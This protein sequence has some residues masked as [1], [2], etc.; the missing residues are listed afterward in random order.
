MTKRSQ[1]AVGDC[2][3]TS[4]VT[5]RVGPV[6]R[7]GRRPKLAIVLS[8]G[9]ARGAYEAGVI[10]YIREDLAA[11]LGGQP[12]FD[13]ICGTSVGALHAC[14]MAATAD[15]PALQ[16][17]LLVERWQDLVLE[18][19]VSFGFKDLRRLPRILFGKAEVE[20]WERGEL[21]L[22]G[23]VET[24][25]LERLVGR[26]M[27][28]RGIR[29]NRNRGLFESLSV[30]TTDVASGKTVVFIDSAKEIPAW[31]RDPHRSARPA[32]IGPRHCLASAAIPLLFPAVAIDK[33]FYADGGLRQ[34]T[35][36]SPA[37]R[38]GADKVLVISLRSD[39]ERTLP[40]NDLDPTPFPS[41]VFLTSKLLDAFLLD[42]LDYDLERLRRLNSLM[43][44]IEK[45]GD[46]PL[47]QAVADVMKK[48][49]GGAYRPVQELVVAPSVNLGRLAAEAAQAGRFKGKGGG[50]GIRLLRR[51]A[52]SGDVSEQSDLLSYILFDGAF[53]ADLAQVGY[54]DARARHDEL[55]A[56]LSDC[57]A[58][59]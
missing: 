48:T 12:C 24:R 35:P 47:R 41:A 46:E 29:R 5:H 31:S 36:L 38:L 26:M 57:V 58:G 56:F 17:R 43:D 40:V 45:Q 19:V 1:L 13:I 27:P 33:R 32:R 15:T 23:V 34:N 8:G 4:T 55:A 54:E 25:N 16:G 7:R 9:G 30:S 11:E 52:A 53:A 21:R 2:R 39:E 49:R 18:E 28:W 10:R 20:Q 14:F 50:L 6:Q 59:A 42:H 51:I 37:L 3:T 44:V 22:G